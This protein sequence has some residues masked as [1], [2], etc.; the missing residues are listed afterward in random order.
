MLDHV[1]IMI[2][3]KNKSDGLDPE[4]QVSFHQEYILHKENPTIKEDSTITN[5]E[6]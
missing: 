4:K 2:I 1:V 3:L 6:K 5:T